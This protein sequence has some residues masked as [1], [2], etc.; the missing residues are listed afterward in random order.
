MGSNDRH[1]SPAVQL[2]QET[3]LIHHEDLRLYRNK[4]GIFNELRSH[5][6][7]LTGG[8]L[9]GRVGG[10][11]DVSGA[12]VLKRASSPGFPRRIDQRRPE[13]LMIIAGIHREY[14]SRPNVGEDDPYP[15]ERPG[16][17]VSSL[18]RLELFSTP[19]SGTQELREFRAGFPLGVGI[20][21]ARWTCL[22]VS[23]SM[24]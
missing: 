21:S 1:L 5:T 16:S 17:R 22:S 19:I 23:A 9:R 13:T 24:K 6:G 7:H 12:E 8:A 14:H 10:P 15:P 4:R 3:D 18:R 2:G 20:Q 11:G